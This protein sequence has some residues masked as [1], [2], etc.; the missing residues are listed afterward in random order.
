MPM[1]IEMELKLDTTEAG[2]A[3]LLASGIA[4]NCE[5]D[6]VLEAVYFDT[7]DRALRRQ[8]LSLRIREE[9]GRI[10]Q[11]VKAA[12]TAIGLF[13][14]GEWECAVDGPWPVADTPAP[15]ADLLGEHF[16]ELAPLFTVRVVRRLRRIEAEGGTIDLA[17]D[18][19]EVLAGERCER[20]HEV[21]LEL[22]SGQ[23][24]ALFDLARRIEPTAPLRIGVLAKADRGY[25]LVDALA[26]AIRADPPVLSAAMAPCD[27]F[28]AI[29]RSCLRQ[30]RLNEDILLRHPTGEAIHQARVALRRLRAAFALFKA[31]LGDHESIALNH[32][33]RDLARTLG[34]ARDLDVL[35]GQAPAGPLRDSLAHAREAALQG[36]TAALSG[37]AKGLM[38]DLAQWLDE[39]AWRDR[40]P[41]PLTLPDFIA[42][43]LDRLH[44]KTRRHG[45]HLARLDD[46]ARHRLRKDAKTLR[47]AAE[48]AAALFDA[49]RQHHRRKPFLKALQR[50]QDALGALN[51]ST[52][53]RQRLNALGLA[54]SPDAATLLAAW[55][56][57]RLTE[58]AARAHRALIARKPF[59]A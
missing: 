17:I 37:A 55:D 39:G 11:A 29:A 58:D 53:A 59:W 23:R 2:A 8:G 10:V 41:G 20:F 49:D 46:T 24:G 45:R 12:G 1:P 18:R 16:A 34:E 27:A 36:V 57:A 6:V 42:A 30:Y 13:T 22:V 7:P 9:D 14:R 52:V 54:A 15:I 4:G 25:R 21:E 43:G 38:L 32:R 19:G 5:G 33:L 3:A 56:H 50:L 40:P 47:Y 26:S 28:A 31:L 44:H 51:D 35:R 48:T